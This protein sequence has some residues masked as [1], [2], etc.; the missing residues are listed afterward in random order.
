MM[1][2]LEHVCPQMSQFGLRHHFDVTRQEH[3]P[4]PALDHEDDGLIVG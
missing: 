4:S 2:D 1:W 3:R